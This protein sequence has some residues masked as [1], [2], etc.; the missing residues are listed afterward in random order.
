MGYNRIDAHDFDGCRRNE[1][2]GSSALGGA[3]YLY[4]RAPVG[5]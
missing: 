2:D 3:T 1:G 4:A 5:Q